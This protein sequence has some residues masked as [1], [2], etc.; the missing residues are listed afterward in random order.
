MASDGRRT[1]IARRSID[2]TDDASQPGQ[3][4]SRMRDDGD[5]GRETG[6]WAVRV[7]AR[8]IGIYGDSG[9]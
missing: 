5:R 4:V 1:R 3:L 7:A 2:S 6:F 9:R 8:E